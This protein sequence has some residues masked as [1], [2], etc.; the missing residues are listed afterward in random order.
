MPSLFFGNLQQIADLGNLAAGLGI[1]GLNGL[2]ADLVQTE[3]LCRCDMAVK[4]AVKALDQLES[5]IRQ[6][7]VP[8][9]PELLPGSCL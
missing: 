5:Q 4:T 2:I 9:T 1:V 6:S 8:L 3:G 7:T